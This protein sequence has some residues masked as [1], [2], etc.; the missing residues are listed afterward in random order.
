[1]WTI[2][3]RTKVSNIVCNNQFIQINWQKNRVRV[4][5]E[6]DSGVV[7]GVT[8]SECYCLKVGGGGHIVYI[9]GEN[10]MLYLSSQK[11]GISELKC[12]WPVILTGECPKIISSPG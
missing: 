3:S 8:V 1:M 12:I 9:L 7:T 4:A 10:Y 2:P 5:I 11:R 6:F